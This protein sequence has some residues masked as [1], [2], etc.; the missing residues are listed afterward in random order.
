[1]V[2]G[3]IRCLFIH[4]ESRNK[5]T[6]LDW[7]ICYKIDIKMYLCREGGGGVPFEY[8]WI[9]MS[10]KPLPYPYQ[11][12]NMYKHIDTMVVISRV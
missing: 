8:L 11:L 1:M 7:F 6:L 2:N 9:P 12:A 5:L 4:M 3:G 10:T